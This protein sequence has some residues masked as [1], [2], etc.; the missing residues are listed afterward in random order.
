[1]RSMDAKESSRFQF[2]RFHI[3]KQHKLQIFL[4][5][6]QQTSLSTTKMTSFWLVYSNI[7]GLP[8]I[9]QSTQ[10]FSRLIRLISM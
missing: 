3:I 5:G 1:M 10:G 2:Y 6:C 4:L 8:R 7:K 9:R